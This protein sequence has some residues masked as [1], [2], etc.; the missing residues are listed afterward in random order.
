[1]ATKINSH[2]ITARLVEIRK[3]VGVSPVDFIPPLHRARKRT[4]R[5]LDDD[6]V[7]QLFDESGLLIDNGSPVFVYIRDHTGHFSGGSP[8]DRNKIHFT[9]CEKLIAMENA[10]RLKSRYRVT[11]RDDNRYWID[12]NAG[13]HKFEE[14]LVTLYPCQHCLGKV[15]RLDFDKTLDKRKRSEKVQSFDA[16]AALNVLREQFETFRSQ[17]TTLESATSPTGYAENWP[18]ISRTYR[19]KKNFTCE[20][21]EGCG[22]NLKRNPRLTDTHHIDGDKTNDDDD[23]LQ[24]LCKLCHKKK[25]PHYWVS[26]SDRREIENARKQQNIS[27]L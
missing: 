25:H 22:V 19:A 3:D 26:E 6:G 18:E 11:N 7:Q 12:V 5:D 14:R 8:G 1:M 21:G 15:P 27:V 20:E 17:T 13:W 4:D 16:K 2:V 9:K 23:N 24:C 10:N